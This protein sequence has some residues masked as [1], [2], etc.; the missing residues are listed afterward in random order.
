MPPVRKLWT[1]EDGLMKYRAWFA[2]IDLIE[3]NTDLSHEELVK[4]M[5][6]YKVDPNRFMCMNVENI[7]GV[8][9]H[10]MCGKANTKYT[11]RNNYQQVLIN[12]LLDDDNTLVFNTYILKEIGNLSSKYH[13][14]NCKIEL[15]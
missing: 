11:D 6:N 9:M 4:R 8:F 10:L 13:L 7:D 2:P 1:K 3:T 14:L 5:K 12:S 15:M